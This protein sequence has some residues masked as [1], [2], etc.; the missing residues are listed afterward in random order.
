MAHQE[1]D[2]PTGPV[3][4]DGLTLEG[5]P[6]P[7][8]GIPPEEATAVPPEPRYPPEQ[9]IFGPYSVYFQSTFPN[10]GPKIP[11]WREL[12][13][14]K[15]EFF[16]CESKSVNS[17]PLPKLRPGKRM[18]SG[19]YSSSGSIGGGTTGRSSLR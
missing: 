2:L 9:S 8:Y 10:F 12:E 6:Y 3:D 7:H 16:D 18:K 15:S 4:S 5:G 17:G 14:D 1:A 13:G 19:V 11:E